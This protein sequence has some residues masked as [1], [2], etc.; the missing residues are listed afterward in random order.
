MEEKHSKAEV[1]QGSPRS[2]LAFR[3]GSYWVSG[4]EGFV[5]SEERERLVVFLSSTLGP[6]RLSRK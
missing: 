2:C 5:L 1:T 4:N 3:E 6:N